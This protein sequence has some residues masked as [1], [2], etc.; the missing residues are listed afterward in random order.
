MDLVGIVI[1]NWKALLDTKNCINSIIETQSG[2]E[3]KIYLVDNYSQDGSYEKII[4][5]YLHIDN[6][7]FIQTGSNFGYSKGNNYGIRAAIND[8]CGYICILNNDVIVFKNTIVPL[9]NLLEQI[10]AIMSR[11]KWFFFCFFSTHSPVG[12]NR[13]N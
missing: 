3:Y 10:R 4:E 13:P 7:T 6:I 9:I 11:R 5:T 2:Y 12:H 8:G 1:L